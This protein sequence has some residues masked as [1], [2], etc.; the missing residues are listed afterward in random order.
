LNEQRTIPRV[1]ETHPLVRQKLALPFTGQSIKDGVGDSEL[2]VFRKRLYRGQKF[3]MGHSSLLLVFDQLYM[4]KQTERSFFGR[5]DARAVRK[6]KDAL[7]GSQISADELLNCVTL[8]RLD[9][10]NGTVNGCLNGL[11]HGYWLL[12]L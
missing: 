10:A 2:N 5:F 9:V 7:I 6:N 1:G 8:F 3:L 12:A 11:A 4:I